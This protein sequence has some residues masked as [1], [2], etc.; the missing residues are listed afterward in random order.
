MKVCALA[1]GVGGAKLASGLQDVLPPGDLSVVVNTADD[2]DLWGLHICPDLDTVMYTLAG[3]SNPE[4]GWGIVN[5]SFE[6]LNML[7][8]YGEETW[9]KLGD[10]DLAT[11]ILRTSRMRSGETLT[12]ITAGLSGALGVESAVLP[13]SDD[14]VSTILDTLEGRL[15][16]QE[17]FVRRGQRDE[18][19]GIELR[20]IEYAMPSERVLAEIG[21]A[22]AIV[23]CPSNPVVSVGPILALPGM[24]EALAS[25]SAPKVA[26]SPI[27]G[28]RALKGP[29]DRMLASLG[30]EVSATGVARM[31]A[32]LVDGMVV[33]RTDEEERAGIE[34]LGIRVLVT[35]SVMRD[36]EDRARLASETLEFS[37]GLVAR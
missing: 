35:Q 15:E 33:D 8:N 31:Y 14:P 16:F 22:D 12:D 11:H 20:G 10:K 3:I 26:V 25:S 13:M 27:V 1:G 9:F 18:V 6:T 4:T 28:G 7:E 24:T 19:L 37:A 34:A 23:F 5:E 29:A 32:G 30:H 36:A 21:G 17:Y 2:F